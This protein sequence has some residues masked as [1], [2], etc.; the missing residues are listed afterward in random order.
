MDFIFGKM[1][2]VG[3]LT[4]A[5]GDRKIYHLFMRTPMQRKYAIAWHSGGARVGK[6]I[7][8]YSVFSIEMPLTSHRL[9]DFDTGSLPLEISP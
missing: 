4:V 6:V 5:L 7:F 2:F 3:L 8:S 1:D 9:Q